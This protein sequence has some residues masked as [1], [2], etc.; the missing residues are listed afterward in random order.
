MSQTIIG[1]TGGIGSGKTAA[2]DHFA[3]FGIAVVDADLASR[4][5]VE[6]GQ[7][8]LSNIAAHFGADILQADGSLDRTKLRHL[9]FA[10]QAQRKWLQSL[11]HPLI[12]AYLRDNLQAATSPYALLVN[13]LLFETQQ[14]RWCSRTLLIDAPEE[15]QLDRTMARDQ[16]T[17]EQVEN[18]MQ[19]QASRS[20]RQALADDIVLNDKDLSHL[21]TEVD[22]LHQAYLKLAA[23]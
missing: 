20:Q 3:S 14:H 4:A 2:A 11:L 1:L 6:P 15:A 17:R 7:P 9:V 18:I 5:V 13:P 23:S 21:H 16:N 22:A 12:N 19:A 8:A 10:D